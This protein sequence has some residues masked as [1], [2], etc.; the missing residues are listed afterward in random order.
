MESL[1]ELEQNKLYLQEALEMLDD[2]RHNLGLFEKQRYYRFRAKL[3]HHLNTPQ[4]RESEVIRI[5][6]FIRPR[7]ES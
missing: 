4:K 6:P 3:E 7:G 2:M 5:S 1:N